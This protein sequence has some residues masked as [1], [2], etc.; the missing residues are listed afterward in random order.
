[1]LIL[2]FPYNGKKSVTSN[3]TDGSNPEMFDRNSYWN[4]SS[5]IILRA[6]ISKNEEM[7]FLDEPKYHLNMFGLYLFYRDI[8]ETIEAF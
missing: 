6:L 4:I 7:R 1:M 5:E 3:W 2:H 8:Y